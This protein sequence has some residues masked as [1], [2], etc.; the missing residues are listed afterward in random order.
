[1]RIDSEP[2][3]LLKADASGIHLFG[4]RAVNCPN[5]PNCNKPFPLS[6]LISKSDPLANIADSIP[7][8]YCMRCELCWEDL[9]YRYHLDGA[10][11]LEQ[12]RLGSEYDEEWDAEMPD[13]L[14]LSHI[15]MK[16]LSV[17]ARSYLEA[18]RSGA[19]LST[20]QVRSFCNEIEVPER[21]VVMGINQFGGDPWCWQMPDPPEC[22]ACNRKMIMMLTLTS[23]IDRC[24]KIC[25]SAWNI[26][27]VA[28]RCAACRM[29]CVRHVA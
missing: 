2:G 4:G 18:L 24:I 19:K 14:P 29:L 8:V 5:C 28:Y 22:V 16:P 21:D 10:I 3:C 27:I 23:G 12:Y 17:M 7:V 26:Q 13:V 9:L 1:M 11:V 25:P 15:K 6:L 20:T